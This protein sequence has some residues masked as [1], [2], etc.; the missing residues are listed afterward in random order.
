MASGRL[1]PRIEPGRGK[2][3][4]RA[5]L[6]LNSRWQSPGLNSVPLGR[7]VTTQTAPDRS[8]HLACD[9]LTVPSGGGPRSGRAG[10]IFSQLAPARKRMLEARA[11]EPGVTRGRVP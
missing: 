9:L 7:G 10:V 2:G 11:G 8:R 3:K 6:H 5:A 1:T 4:E